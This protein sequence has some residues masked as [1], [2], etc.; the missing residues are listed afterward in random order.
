MSRK[1]KPITLL[2]GQ[3]FRTQ[4]DFARAC[5]LPGPVVSTLLKTRS[6]NLI[7][8]DAGI[9]RSPLNPSLTPRP[10]VGPPPVSQERITSNDLATGGG[11]GC[12]GSKIGTL[13]LALL[14]AAREQ[15]P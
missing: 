10:R 14:D 1:P 8:S 15:Q 6:P 3:T 2:D 4:G 7:A 13:G 12:R 5:R 9:L 11:R